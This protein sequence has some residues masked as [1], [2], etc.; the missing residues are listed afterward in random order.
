MAFGND[1]DS[2]PPVRS[3]LLSGTEYDFQTTAASRED[4]SFVHSMQSA[5]ELIVAPI[6][7]YLDKLINFLSTGVPFDRDFEL[8]RSYCHGTGFE[9]SSPKFLF[10]L[11]NGCR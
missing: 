3:G 9:E 5:P 8:Q 1:E 6:V 11:R 10:S 7:I 2:S 4:V